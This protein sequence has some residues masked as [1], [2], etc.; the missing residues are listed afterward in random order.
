MKLPLKNSVAQ[1][2]T[3][4]LYIVVSVSIA[5]EIKK[6][7]KITWKKSCLPFPLKFIFADLKLNTIEVLREGSGWLCKIWKKGI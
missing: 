7:G 5:L 6:V 4:S 2:S 3:Q 1:L